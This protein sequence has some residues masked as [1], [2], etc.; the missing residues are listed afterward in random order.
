[1][2]KKF[3]PVGDKVIVKVYKLDEV[4]SGGIILPGI[5][6]ESM[7][8]E[9]GE[10]LAMGDT[11]FGEAYD[12]FR[13]VVKVGDTIAFPRYGGKSLGKDDEGNDIRVMRDVDILCVIREA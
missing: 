5:E 13:K 4:T 10:V 1:M 11:I 7:A 8:R 6:K 2:S 9:E 12:D 3:I